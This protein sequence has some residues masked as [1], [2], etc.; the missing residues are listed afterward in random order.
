[1]APKKKTS[2]GRWR[3]SDRGEHN[4][5]AQV[6]RLRY[7]RK[8]HKYRQA[9]EAKR[10]VRRQQ[11]GRGDRSAETAKRKRGD[12]SAESAKRQAK[13]HSRKQAARELPSGQALP[14][15][16]ALPQ[17]MKAKELK[18]AEEL[19]KAKEWANLKMNARRCRMQRLRPKPGDD[20]V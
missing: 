18:K 7:R 20:L 2:S 12:R 15:G 1:M 16:Q 13:R 14:T 9:D 11:Y 17:L 4:R 5:R 10:K 3:L 6:A 19:K 8:I